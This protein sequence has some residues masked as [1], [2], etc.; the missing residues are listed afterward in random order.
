VHDDLA[1]D[2]LGDSRLPAVE[3]VD[4]LVDDAPDVRVVRVDLIPPSPQ[5]LD[6]NTEIRHAPDGIERWDARVTAPRPRRAGDTLAPA[7]RRR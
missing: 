4:R 6:L 1:V 2:D 3:P 7:R 5:L